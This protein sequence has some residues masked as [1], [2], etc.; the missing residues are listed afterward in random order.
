MFQQLYFWAKGIVHFEINFW[1]VL[2]YLKMLVSLFPQYFQFLY[3]S[4][5]P[6]FSVME[7]YCENK[8]TNILD[9]LEVS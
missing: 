7:I 9:A 3:F 2:A 8:D 5:K 1:Y 4:V 6:L